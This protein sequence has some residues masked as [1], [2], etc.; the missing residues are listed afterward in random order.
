VKNNVCILGM[1]YVGLTLAA[2]MSEKGF[3]VF[4]VEIDD[5]KLKT[6]REGRSHFLEV[7]LDMTLER[8]IKNR[9]L[10]FSKEI[11]AGQEFDAYIVT[12]GT[13][14]DHDGNPRMDMI[15]N[16]GTDISNHLAPGALII[17]RSTVKV[18][19]T[20][21]IVKPILDAAGK[22]YYL[23][24]CP[25]RT[26]EG[27]AMEELNYLPQIIGGL[28]DKSVQ[29]AEE[30]FSR[31]TSTIHRLSSLESAELIKLLD[32]SFRDVF[33]SFGNE[34]ALMCEALGLSSHEIINA[35]NMG[36]SRTN[37]ANPGF[38]GGPCLEKDPYILDHS[39]KSHNYSPDL[40]KTARKLNESVVDHVFNH[41]KTHL[42]ENPKPV[43]TL[44]G[45]AFK[46]TPDTDDLRGSAALDLIDAFNSGMPNAT[47][48]GQDYFVKD[49]EIEKLGIKPVDEIEAFEKA[50]LV[51]IL[52]NNKKYSWIDYG[53]HSSFLNSSGMI[54]DCW[55]VVSKT[56]KLAKGVSL[57][58][59][60]G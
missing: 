51:I 37:I 33:F 17:L 18:G 5:E 44:M 26:I 6:I 20:R 31:I 59:L 28:N 21:D 40:I 22:E 32:N 35:A 42:K 11:P 54:Y 56:T 15:E 47:L 39:L 16:V 8:G 30:I 12:V 48:R 60:G 46:G 50:D 52:N 4:G 7:G 38:V 13:P 24:F 3:N 45:L 2:A 27:K 25:E 19:T 49:E 1:G 14:L 9:T 36:Y 43:I 57:N 55:G 34:V 10:S 58:V 29:K 23:A 41:V 53:K